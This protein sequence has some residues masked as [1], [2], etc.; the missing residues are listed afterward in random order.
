MASTV[1]RSQSNGASLGCGDDVA[2]K[3]ELGWFEFPGNRR[4][5]AIGASEKPSTTE[6]IKKNGRKL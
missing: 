3:V 2:N 5:K 4:Q 1:T 6:A